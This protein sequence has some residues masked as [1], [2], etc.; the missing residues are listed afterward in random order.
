MSLPVRS[1][2]PDDAVGVDD[3]RVLARPDMRAELEGLAVTIQ[4]GVL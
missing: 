3:G 1:L 4:T 2:R